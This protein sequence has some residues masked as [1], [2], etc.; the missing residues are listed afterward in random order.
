MAN[1]MKWQLIDHQAIVEIDDKPVRFDLSKLFMDFVNM[2]DVQKNVIY[3]GLKQKLA[4]SCAR[5]SDE[6][7]N[8]E[9][10]IDQLNATYARLC[11]GNWS[12]PRAVGRKVTPESLLR[13]IEKLAGEAGNEISDDV[14]EKLLKLFENK[15][16]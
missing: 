4:D 3:Y 1:R 16:K 11:D 10:T 9:E 13:G 15:S 5:K 2:D 7:L 12:S 14:R 6:T 8:T